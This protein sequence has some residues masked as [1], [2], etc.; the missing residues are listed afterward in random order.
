[1]AFARLFVE[2]LRFSTT[3]ATR[4]NFRHLLI[5]GALL[6]FGAIAAGCHTFHDQNQPGS[7]AATRA[8]PAPGSTGPQSGADATRASGNAAAGTSATSAPTKGPE[9]A[10]SSG[11]QSGPN[12]AG[13]P[14]DQS[15]KNK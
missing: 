12:P 7:A 13:S 10:G 3:G 4:M 2:P 15:I 11:T 14:D 1:M 5:T 8:G 9:A 6:S